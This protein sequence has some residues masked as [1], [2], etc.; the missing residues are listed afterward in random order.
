MQLS[1]L[2]NVPLRKTLLSARQR[3]AGE[4]HKWRTRYDKGYHLEYGFSCMGYEIA[5]GLASTGEA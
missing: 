5:G 3:P 4:L 1:A 2:L